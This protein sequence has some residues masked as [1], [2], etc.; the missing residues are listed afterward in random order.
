MDY[1]KFLDVYKLGYAFD[2]DNTT[3]KYRNMELNTI[4]FTLLNKLAGENFIRTKSVPGLSIW[5]TQ[6]RHPEKDMTM[7]R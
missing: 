1:H 3:Q 4:D 7:T 5:K 2:L 6:V